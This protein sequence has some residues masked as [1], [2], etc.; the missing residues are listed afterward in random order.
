[1]SFSADKLGKEAE[2]TRRDVCGK[3]QTVIRK[4]MLPTMQLAGIAIPGMRGALMTTLHMRV[5][6][7][8]AEKG[9]ESSFLE[10]TVQGR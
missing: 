3:E 5:H 9:A 2:V 4:I 6:D 7:K 10:E 8:A 1:M